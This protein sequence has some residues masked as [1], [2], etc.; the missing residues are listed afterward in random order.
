MAKV[1]EPGVNRQNTLVNIWSGSKPLIKVVLIL[2]YYHPLRKSI[3]IHNFQS[4]NLSDKPK[5]QHVTGDLFR[6][7]GWREGWD[8]LR[9]PE[10]LL[11]MEKWAATSAWCSSHSAAASSVDWWARGIPSRVRGEWA[12]SGKLGHA[13]WA[14]CV[15]R[16]YK[17]SSRAA[18]DAADSSS[19]AQLTLT[20]S[21]SISI[22]IM[23]LIW[24][25]FGVKHK[26]VKCKV[27]VIHGEEGCTSEVRLCA[28][29]L[30][31][32]MYAHLYSPL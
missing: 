5:E 16:G 29:K 23:V 12:C 18:G 21:R 28:F 17:S 13:A 6:M 9:I 20:G 31:A 15:E 30:H 11:H 32:Y 1:F 4:K 8:S 2:I 7:D 14:P 3:L 22:S 24:T 19:S 25:Q 27:R 26:N 10:A